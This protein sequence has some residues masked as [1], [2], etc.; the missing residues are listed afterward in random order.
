MRQSYSPF[1]CTHC[2]QPIHWVRW[3]R[4]EINHYIEL[5]WPCFDRLDQA[6]TAENAIC[7]ALIVIGIHQGKLGV[8]R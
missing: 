5:C 2:Q 4:V 8:T 6:L 1:V 3:A 7:A